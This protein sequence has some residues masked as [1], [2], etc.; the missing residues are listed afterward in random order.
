MLYFLFATVIIAFFAGRASRRGHSRFDQIIKEELMTSEQK[1]AYTTV[2]DLRII[3]RDFGPGADL[4]EHW[5]AHRFALPLGFNEDDLMTTVDAL[6]DRLT[7][8]FKLCKRKDVP[9]SIV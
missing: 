3:R 6:I 5:I 7:S 2:C 8:H 4:T 1:A 9:A